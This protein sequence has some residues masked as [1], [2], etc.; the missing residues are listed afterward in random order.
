MAARRR[1][2]PQRREGVLAWVGTA[3]AGLVLIVAGFGAGVLLG[4]VSE[5]P[6][7]LAGVLTGGKER[8]ALASGR[9]DEVTGEQPAP[10]PRMAAPER[11][12]GESAGER[13]AR[14][15][16]VARERAQ[17]E[18]RD[19]PAVS[20]APTG[21]AVQVGA[22]ASS[23][24][25]RAMRSKLAAKGY[26]SFVAAGAAARGQRWRV[27][28]GPFAN[29]AQADRAAWQLKRREGISTWVVDLNERNR[30]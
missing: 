14:A 28:V 12:S 19:L 27:R 30:N 8:V 17:P 25:A 6:A 9:S 11:S 18:G 26:E 13:T 4:V 7:A 23:E 15:T 10:A 3:L 16:P 1:T 2:R 22:F 5:E 24:A 21:Y 20:A 29:R